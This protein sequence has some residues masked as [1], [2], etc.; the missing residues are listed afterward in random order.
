MVVLE[1]RT[2]KSSKTLLL[3]TQKFFLSL[4]SSFLPHQ[5]LGINRGLFYPKSL[6]AGLVVNEPE[7]LIIVWVL[8]ITSS[9]DPLWQGSK[10]SIRAVLFLNEG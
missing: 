5:A 8:F 7:S 9:A 4:Y 1:R 6:L 3:A 10:A 2:K